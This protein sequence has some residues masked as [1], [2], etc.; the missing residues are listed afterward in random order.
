VAAKSPLAL[1]LEA[2]LEPVDQVLRSIGFKAKGR[3]YNRRTAEDIVHVVQ[4]RMTRS[5]PP[6]TPEIPGFREDLYG[7]FSVNLGIYV[8][9]VGRHWMHW[10]P[11]RPFPGEVDCCIRLDLTEVGPEATPGLWKINADRGT[12]ESIVMR[13]KRD[14]VPFFAHYSTRAPFLAP[15]FTESA[16][17]GTGGP[18]RVIAA[19]IL[20]EMGRREEALRLLHDQSR[21]VSKPGHTEVLQGLAARL[22]IDW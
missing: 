16:D 2:G 1:K 11:V 5:D 18:P 13:L 15:A 6:G 22:G 21:R 10:Q 20:A 4:V 19:I 9:E 17:Y 7:T 3:V 8:P 14:A 12:Y